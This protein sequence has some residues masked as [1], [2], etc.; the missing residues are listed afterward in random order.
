M[1]SP[2]DPWQQ[3]QQPPLGQYP[4]G[5]QP[6]GQYL[7]QGTPSGGFPQQGGYA[8]Y[9]QYSQ[10]QY[11]QYQQLE[12]QHPQYPGDPR[13]AGY[14]QNHPYA[15][16]PV[17]PHDMAGVPRPKTIEA[18]FWIAVV[19]PVL[20]TVMF[21]VSTFL[22]REAM[23]AVLSSTSDPDIQE[24]AGS[25]AM[26]GIGIMVFFYVVLTGLW[27]LF[28][29]KM[30]AGRNWAR[31]TLTVFAGLWLFVSLLQLMGATSTTITAGGTSTSLDS[32]GTAMALA[33]TTAAVSFLAMVVFI[34]LAY[35]RPSNWFFQAA[36]RR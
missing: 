1:T 30:R 26:V 36:R 4:P 11:F 5:Q 18:A 15:A 8:Q 2:Q 17:S 28:G 31:V 10:Y 3:N 35:L 29:F 16:P 19:V 23:N 34:V 32:S 7:Q 24:M 21:V 6:P 9:P 12:Y 13:Q 33:Y 27:I 25:V 22:Q 20:A 14:P